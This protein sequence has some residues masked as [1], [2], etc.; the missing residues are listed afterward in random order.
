MKNELND[1]INERTDGDLV[2]L[3]NE[4]YD[5]DK[6]G[7]LDPDSLLSRILRDSHIESEDIK[8][9]ILNIS[10]ERLGKVVL[11]LLM[12]RPN[13]FLKNISNK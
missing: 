10:A 13:K 8:E 7:I 6:T 5:W 4:F 11:L 1:L 9:I 2:M 3:C 12:K